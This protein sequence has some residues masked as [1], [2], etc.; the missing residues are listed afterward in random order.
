[1]VKDVKKNVKKEDD[2]GV[3]ANMGSGK[4]EVK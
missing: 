2:V 4:G 1:M 3:T